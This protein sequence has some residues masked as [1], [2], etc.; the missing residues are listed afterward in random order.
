MT[1]DQL[2]NCGRVM[3]GLLTEFDAETITLERDGERLL[4]IR[5]DGLTYE[6]PSGTIEIP[7]AAFE[8]R[9]EIAR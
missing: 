4:C 3:R 9:W 5:G 1:R 6:H 2:I 7:E 8:D